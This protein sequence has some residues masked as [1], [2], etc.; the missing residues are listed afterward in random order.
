M[1]QYPVQEF[2]NL[3]FRYRVA[4]FTKVILFFIFVSTFGCGQTEKNLSIASKGN[5][6]EKFIVG[7]SN[8]FSGNSWRAEM[9]ASLQQ[10]AVKHPEAELIVLDGEGSINK[11]VM[12]IEALIARKVDAILLIPNSEVA[13]VPV[14]KKAI[15]MG[16]KVVHFNLPLEDPECYHVYVGPDEKE[17][18]KIWAQWLVGKLNGQGS[19]VMFGG[20]PGNPGTAAAVEGAL[21]VFKATQIKVLAYRDSYWQEERG[22][23][24]MGELIS[25]FPT[26]DGIWSDGGQVTAGAIR[27]LLESGRPLIPVTGDDY[28]GMFKLY[29]EY[30]PRNPRFDFAAIA[31]P[32]WQ[33]KIAFQKAL[34][35]LKGKPVEKWVKIEPRLITGKDAILFAKPT[36]SDSVFVDTDLPDTVLREIP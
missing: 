29:L 25:K 28:N 36:L 6:K 32:T 33:S 4:L 5:V 9:L 18:G 7:F 21:E 22:K 3:S 23:Q 19:I 30:H 16:I 11:Q 26:I 14:L 10:E 8:G 1:M 15:V 27:A 2:S 17:R 13:I 35:L 24:I 31:T 20:I 12:D 34:D